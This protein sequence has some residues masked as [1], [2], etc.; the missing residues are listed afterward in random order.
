[1][2]FPWQMILSRMEDHVQEIDPTNLNKRIQLAVCFSWVSLAFPNMPGISLRLAASFS[3]FP[4][5]SNTSPRSQPLLAAAKTRS[6]GALGVDSQP[7]KKNSHR[8]P[9]ASNSLKPSTRQFLSPN[10]PTEHSPRPLH[11]QHCS[12]PTPAEAGRMDSA[13]ER[14]GARDKE[15][16]GPSSRTWRSCRHIGWL[17]KNRE[18]G[19]GG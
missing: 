16:S 2:D 14:S 1:M 12:L 10:S 6:L 9:F 8:R 13:S 18:G 15:L 19:R 4:M 11:P 3:S 5:A 17:P 7:P